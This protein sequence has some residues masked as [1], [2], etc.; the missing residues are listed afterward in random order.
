MR[1]IALCD[2]YKPMVCCL[3]AV[4]SVLVCISSTSAVAGSPHLLSTPPLHH[5]DQLL[6]RCARSLL[7]LLPPMPIEVLVRAS[8]SCA[9]AVGVIQVAPAPLLT[10]AELIDSASA[11]GSAVPLFRAVGHCALSHAILRAQ[12]ALRCFFTATHPTCRNVRCRQA[13]VWGCLML[14]S[15]V[16]TAVG[17]PD[18]IRRFRELP[19]FSR[20]QYPDGLTILVA[21]TVRTS[22]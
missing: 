2:F 22:Q 20:H 10:P 1:H 17:P 8:K 21:S 11:R 4:H 9:A 16:G 13:A 14:R 19:A 6:Q 15:A 3:M 5:E 12:N 7:M 18:W